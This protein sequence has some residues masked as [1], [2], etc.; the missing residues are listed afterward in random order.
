MKFAELYPSKRLTIISLNS[1]A[2]CASAV[3]FIIL[4]YLYD[5][6]I[7]Y[8]MVMLILTLLSLLM[9][10][11][12]K[13][14]SI[15]VDIVIKTLNMNKSIY[16]A[17]F[18]FQTLLLFHSSSGKQSSDDSTLDAFFMP[19]FLNKSNSNLYLAYF[20]TK[21]FPFF[22]RAINLSFHLY[23]YFKK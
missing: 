20:I 4:K 1:G 2:T 16:F 5:S 13:Y 10:Q 21:F 22:S 15:D 3:V 23:L 17:A 18:H 7:S 8:F 12:F 11:P 14:H 19:Q 9:F 6:G